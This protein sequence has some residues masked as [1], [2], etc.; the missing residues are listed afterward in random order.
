VIKIHKM[1]LLFHI[2]QVVE[3]IPDSLNKY[4]QKMRLSKKIHFWSMFAN[5]CVQ[6]NIEVADLEMF[7]RSAAEGRPGG[8]ASRCATNARCYCA[9]FTVRR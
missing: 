7:E 4:S 1:W 5:F 2:F 3:H 8:A 6:S 9:S